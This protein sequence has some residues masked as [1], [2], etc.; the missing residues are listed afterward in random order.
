[1]YTDDQGATVRVHEASAPKKPK[2][3][4]KTDEPKQLSLVFEDLDEAFE[5][6]ERKKQAELEKRLKEEE[7]LIAEAKKKAEEERLKAEA[8]KVKEEPEAKPEVKP[9]KSGNKGNGEQLFKQCTK[10]WCFDCKHNARNE[11]V[12]REMCGVSMPCPACKSCEAEDFATIC[13]IGNAKEG[14]KFRAIEEGLFQEEESEE[15]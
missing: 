12:P 10:C 13:E 9:S 8:A 4:P 6:E 15:V 5:E 11:G 7:R 1:E 14:C 3:K 2:N